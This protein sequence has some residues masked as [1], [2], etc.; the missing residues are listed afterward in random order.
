VVLLA[1]AACLSED[2][3][4]AWLSGRLQPADLLGVE[5]HAASCSACLRRIGARRGE[6]A[7]P[8]PALELEAPTPGAASEAE[9]LGAWAELEAWSIG[10][11]SASQ[12]SPKPAAP[13]LVPELLAGRYELKALLGQG[14]MGEVYGGLDRKTG[15]RVAIKRLKAG[16][17]AAHA[18]VLA[19]FAREAEI[20]RRLDHP[21]IVKMLDLVEGAEQHSIV[22]DY[23]AGGS[24]RR[25][26]AR[27]PVLPPVEALLLTLEVAEALASAHGSQVIH[28]DVKPENVLIGDDGAVLLADFGLA[29]LGERGFTAPG[30]VLGTVAYLSPETLWGL[31]VDERTDLWSLG[32]MLF[33]MLSGVRPFVA[34]T[35][36]AT[37]TAILQQPVPSLADVC[38]GT[39]E[40][41]VALSSR[42]LQKKREQRMASA[43]EVVSEIESILE[44]LMDPP[45]ETPMETPT[46]RD[47]SGGAGG[48]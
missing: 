4:D 43:A 20:L 48:L 34:S 41:V 11:R 37:L 27:Q 25:E 47:S 3:L 16:P 21:N 35:P 7:R 10:R 23:V 22:M 38:P 29:R 32:V 45:M 33:E 24:L 39:S 26:L 15:R 42:L 5:A 28:R 40:Q 1:S 46:T 36:G 9:T 6:T 30:T 44:A 31:E 17:G 12:Y 2:V 19:R 18:E 14:G 8:G 13:Q